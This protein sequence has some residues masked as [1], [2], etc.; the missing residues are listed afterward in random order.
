VI[1]AALTEFQPFIS[2]SAA[3]RL[4]GKSRATLHRQRHPGPAPETPPPT[5]RPAPSWALTDTER[6]ALLAVLN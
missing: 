2:T 1:D 5:A 3:C 4:L 6:A